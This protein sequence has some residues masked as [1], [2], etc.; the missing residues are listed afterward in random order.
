MDFYKLYRQRPEQYGI[1]MLNIARD[2]A[3]RLRRAD[4]QFSHVAH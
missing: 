1:V 2:L 3:R 4:E